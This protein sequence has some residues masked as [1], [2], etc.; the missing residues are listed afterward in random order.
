M[1]L[2][3]INRQESRISEARKLYGNIATARDFCEVMR[4]YEHEI[5]GF[6]L[7]FTREGKVIKTING[8]TLDKRFIEWYT[9]N[10]IESVEDQISVMEKE[11]HEI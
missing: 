10:I 5:D 7:N 2:E 11:V 3:E 8:R 4:R 9:R 6:N 1:T